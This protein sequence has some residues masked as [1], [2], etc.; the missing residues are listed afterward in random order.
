M[1]TRLQQHA[2]KVFDKSCQRR[3]SSA[4]YA[5]ADISIFSAVGVAPLISSRA[6]LVLRSV[7][8]FIVMII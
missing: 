3:N 1:K 8:F 2:A 5:L 6:S 4:L 7:V